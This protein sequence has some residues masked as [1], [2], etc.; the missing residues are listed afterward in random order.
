[1]YSITMVKIIARV[2]LD[3]MEAMDVPKIDKKIVEL[4]RELRQEG[5]F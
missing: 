3:T 1:M 4:I 5:R 2:N